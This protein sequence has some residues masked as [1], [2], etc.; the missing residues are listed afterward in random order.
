MFSAI[1]RFVRICYTTPTPIW[2][3]VRYELECFQ[4]LMIFLISPWRLPWCSMVTATD[5]SLTGFGATRAN[6]PLE[7]VQDLGR[8]PERLRFKKMPQ[9]SSRVK[10]LV[11]AGVYT[12]IG[13]P[14]DEGQEWLQ[15]MSFQEVPAEFLLRSLWQ[16]CM[17]GIWQDPED[18]SVLEKGRI[19]KRATA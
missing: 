13:G 2:K 5:S 18:I 10:A 14:C 17:S 15:D 16:D 3:S 19:N 12:H 4:H 6:L 11:Q 8:N 1:Y 7:V 9:G